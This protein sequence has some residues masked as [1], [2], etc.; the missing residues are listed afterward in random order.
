MLTKTA[1]TLTAQSP[2]SPVTEQGTIIG[3]FQYMSHPTA[4]AS[5]STLPPTRTSVPSPPPKLDLSSPLQIIPLVLPESV[6][7]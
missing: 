7:L 3:T 4:S 5:S 2:F 1:A 6:I